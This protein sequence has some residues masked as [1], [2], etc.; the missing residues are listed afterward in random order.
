[1]HEE[2]YKNR[3][4]PENC[5]VIGDIP[6]TGAGSEGVQGPP[7]PAGPPG[8]D[9]ARGERGLTG[10]PGPA[11]PQ[12]PIGNSVTIERYLETEDDLDS[13]GLGLEDTGKSYLTL[14]TG[15]LY[16]WTGTQFN[17]VGPIVG[18]QGIP[19]VDG[20][21]GDEGPQGERGLPGT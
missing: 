1:M 15:R 10:D 7:G 11:G 12:G 3:N 14:D 17:D 20:A 5:M 16:F 13:L 2:D 18:P 8:A 6:G 4:K 19:G 21:R 9:G